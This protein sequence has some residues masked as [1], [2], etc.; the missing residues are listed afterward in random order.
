[1]RTR[2]FGGDD[3]RR[4]GGERGELA[5]CRVARARRKQRTFA[6]D[7]EAGAQFTAGAYGGEVRGAGRSQSIPRAHTARSAD[8]GEWHGTQSASPGVSAGGDPRWKTSSQGHAAQEEEQGDRLGRS[9]C[10]QS[11][12]S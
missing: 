7:R 8:F 9:T 10:Q 4:S 1:R 5:L 2:V 11:R 6:P 3:V 12:F